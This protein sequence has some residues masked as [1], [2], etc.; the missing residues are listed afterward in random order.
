MGGGLESARRT[1]IQL[2]SATARRARPVSRTQRRARLQDDVEHMTEEQLEALEQRLAARRQRLQEEA[3]ATQAEPEQED[4]DLVQGE[5]C[6]TGGGSGS[7]G[8]GGGPASP[9]TEATEAREAEEEDEETG[10]GRSLHP[11]RSS[12]PSTP[13]RRRS[14][15][16]GARSRSA[17]RTRQEGSG[18]V[19]APGVGPPGDRLMGLTELPPFPRIVECMATAHARRARG[20]R[21]ILTPEGLFTATNARDRNFSLLPESWTRIDSRSAA[22]T[23]DPCA[24]LS[25]GSSGGR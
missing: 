5:S 3:E 6:R 17:S 10:R 14:K 16:G 25:G 9:R 20:P 15:S 23:R 24:T 4:E 1:P 19:P 21:D 22:E 13:N 11:K 7:G 12:R 18:T 8:G 2:T